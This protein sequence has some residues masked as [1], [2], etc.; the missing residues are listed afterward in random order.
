MKGVKKVLEGRA[1]INL[2]TKS[3]WSTEQRAKRKIQCQITNAK[4]NGT[5]EEWNNDQAEL[6]DDSRQREIREGKTSNDPAEC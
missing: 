4:N 2:R 1:H 3:A 5:V 6:P